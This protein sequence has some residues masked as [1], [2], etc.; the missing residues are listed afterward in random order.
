M[1]IRRRAEAARLHARAIIPT[2]FLNT[3]GDPA[4]NPKGW[5]VA[6]LGE[7]IGAITGGK[8]LQARNGSS[9]YRI[10]KVSA[11]TSGVL[12]PLKSKPAP[13]NH[14]PAP[15]HHVRNGD[16][17]FSRANTSELVGAVAIAH[18]P[19]ESLLLPDK[20][21]RIEWD[22]AKIDPLFAYSLFRTSDVRRVFAQIAS[23]TSSSMKNISQ[24][25]L[26]RV[27]IFIPPLDLQTS[28]AKQAQ[29]IEGLARSLDAAAA[30]AKSMA[31][32]L[33]A[34]VLAAPDMLPGGTNG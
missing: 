23:G 21:W 16:F 4:T 12:K 33:S 24:A 6:A 34:E 29:R 28:F 5:P 14:I 18:N 27:T 17:L 22:A 11:V 10:L 13:D 1:E 2:L 3:F 31:A 32:A 19:P 7:V 30:R 9:A 8:N 15:V 26:R 20:I 25:K